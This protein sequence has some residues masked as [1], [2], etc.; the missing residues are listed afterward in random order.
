MF[1]AIPV[2]ETG[3]RVGAVQIGGTLTSMDI[4]ALFCDYVLIS[5]EL[6]AASAIIAGDKIA[7][8][9][10]AGEDWIKII[11]LVIIFA[12]FLFSAIGSN[13]IVNLLGM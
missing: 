4:I 10:I 6:Y 12:G 3:S 9:T 8:A 7:V 2:M 11:T 13:A 5:E 1:D